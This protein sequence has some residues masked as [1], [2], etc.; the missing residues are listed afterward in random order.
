MDAH[1]L[2]PSHRAALNNAVL[3]QLQTLTQ[4][5]DNEAIWDAFHLLDCVQFHVQALDPDAVQAIHMVR[6]PSLP[7]PH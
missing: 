2:Q 6:N 1:L 5:P 7:I 4:R 3:L